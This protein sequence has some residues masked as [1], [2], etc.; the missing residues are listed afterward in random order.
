MELSVIIPLYNAE[1]YL[2]QCLETLL[3]VSKD[4][5]IILVNDG[6][7][8]NTEKICKEYVGKYNNI[9]YFVQENK[10]VSSA[11]N[12][13]LQHVETKY[14]MFVDGDD[15]IDVNRLEIV[16]EKCS[17][18]D[19]ELCITNYCNFDSNGWKEE[20]SFNSYLEKQE[21]DILINKILT[22]GLLNTCW[23]KI[24]QTDIIQRNN[25]YFL[26]DVK[27]GEDIIFLLEYLKHINTYIYINEC[28]Y[29]YRKNPQ[30]AMNQRISLT[31]IDDLEKSYYKRIEIAKIYMKNKESIFQEI[32]FYY[33]TNILYLVLRNK[34]N[35][36][37]F[38]E[39]A[40]IIVN[41]E[42]FLEILNNLPVNKLSGYEKIIWMFLKK[43]NSLFLLIFEKIR[44]KIRKGK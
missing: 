32:N 20:V 23:A 31:R 14:V 10:G 7:C 27:I 13:G 2:Q 18:V 25:L 37:D 11:R 1:N 43:K 19:F 9:Q 21:F 33:F 3:N 12:N 8:D 40:D 42:F 28:F 29:Y 44:K 17:K 41:K 36:S 39:F 4:L 16:I 30:S 15:Y 26:T 35:D 5:K 22:D 38:R 6:S 24:Y 34:V